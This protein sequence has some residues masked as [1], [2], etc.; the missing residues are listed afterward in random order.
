MDLRELLGSTDVYLIDQ[1][2][3]GRFAPPLRVLD[4]GCGSGRNLDYLLRTGCDVYAVDRSESAVRQTRKRAHR[5]AAAL[6]DSNFRVE[7][8]EELGFQAGHFDLVISSAVL[9]FATDPAHFESMLTELWRVV[10][11]GG[12]LFVRTASLE[13]LD[14]RLASLGKGHYR[15]PDGSDRYL[16]ND[17][18]L[19]DWTE[20]LGAT[21][22]EPLKTVF[23]SG[24]R[25]MASWIVSKPGGEA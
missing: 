17:A 8:V 13:G 19:L 14:G 2:L 5:L 6:P 24:Q 15:L 4:A 12:V 10:R 21:L 1:F 9:H 25:S 18:M 22:L 7:S 11:P 3:K 16:V 23:V 20:R